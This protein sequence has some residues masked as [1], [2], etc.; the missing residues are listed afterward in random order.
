MMSGGKVSSGKVSSRDFEKCLR[1][2]VKGGESERT[3]RPGGEKRGLAEQVKPFGNRQQE[4]RLNGG[5]RQVEKSMERLPGETVRMRRT[6]A[7]TRQEA[8]ERFGRYAGCSGI[9]RGTGPRSSFRE[10]L[11]LQI[12]F[13]GLRMW[14]VQTVLFTVL[15]SVLWILMGRGF[16]QEER[17]MARF[18]CRLSLAAAVSS[19]PFIYRSFRYRMHE[20][21]ASSRYSFAGVLLAKMLMTAMG[22][23]VLL[24]VVFL[25]AVLGTGLSVGSTFLYLLLPFLL[26][27]WLG[28]SLM[29]RIPATVF[30]AACMA[31]GAVLLA[32]A[33]IAGRLWDGFYLQTLTPGWLAV[34]A[35]ITL[36]CIR[37]AKRSVR[38]AVY[39]ELQIA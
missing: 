2:A 18:L 6:A 32:A 27:S 24:G 19:L 16:W 25:G 12:R 30:P 10:F 3:K 20:T 38:D 22:D 36:L 29:G 34:C 15:G 31:A 13:I 11:L 23:A 8:E 37:Q 1:M 21:E 39:P 33:G 4:I 5:K 35:L 9:M 7:L 14:A 28:L 17:Y 26:A